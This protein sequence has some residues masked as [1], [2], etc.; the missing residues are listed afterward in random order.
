MLFLDLAPLFLVIFEL[1]QHLHQGRGRNV[2]QTFLQRAWYRKHSH[3]SRR[4]YPERR[5]ASTASGLPGASR[6]SRT[7]DGMTREGQHA[8]ASAGNGELPPVPPGAPDYT[9]AGAWEVGGLIGVSAPS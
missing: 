8:V 5:S 2:S 9:I 4:S 6:A 1:A 7:A 3:G